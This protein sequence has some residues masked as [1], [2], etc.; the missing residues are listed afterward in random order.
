[1]SKKFAD[2]LEQLHGSVVAMGRHA[3][4]MVENAI[5]A[6]GSPERKTLI[7]KVR[8]SEPKLDQMQLDLD[9]VAIRLM[10]TY[11][12]VAHALRV[13]ISVARITSELERMGD[14]AINMCE[15]IQLASDDHRESHP[16]ALVQMGSLVREMVSQTLAALE[17]SSQELAHDTILMD[18]R[19]DKANDEVMER[20]LS[21]SNQFELSVSLSQILIAQFLE[22]IADQCTNV[23]EEIIYMDQGEDVRHQA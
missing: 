15:S 19:V 21:D 5:H 4:Q 9:H 1:M 7:A 20:H 13:S 23:C 16:D 22:R 8:Q 3:Q 18:D 2:E 10:A 14:N 12:P 11:S 6:I 17:V